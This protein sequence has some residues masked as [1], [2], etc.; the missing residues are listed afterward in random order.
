MGELAV[1]TP[2][3][4]ERIGWVGERLYTMDHVTEGLRWYI[5]QFSAEKF[6][7]GVVDRLWFGTNSKK[8]IGELREAGLLDVISER[9]VHLKPLETEAQRNVIGR[10][11][12]SAVLSIYQHPPSAYAKRIRL[13]L[14][15]II[16]DLKSGSRRFVETEE[17][18]ETTE[19]KRGTP[20]WH[21]DSHAAEVAD[22]EARENHTGQYGR[23]PF[24]RGD[25][26]WAMLTVAQIEKISDFKHGEPLRIAYQTQAPDGKIAE[27]YGEYYSQGNDKGSRIIAISVKDGKKEHQIR[28]FHFDSNREG[29][30][31]LGLERVDFPIIIK[32][33]PGSNFEIKAQ[34][35]DTEPKPEG[36]FQIKV[37]GKRTK[38]GSDAA[39]NGGIDLSQ[40]G[41]A[42]HI[43]KDANGGVKVDVDP[44]LIARVE[45]EGMSEIDPVIIGMRPADI[46]SL[47]GVKVLTS[48][49]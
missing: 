39:M 44:A 4:N 11:G 37:V 6:P 23:T 28:M 45:R 34:K 33:R 35:R 42:L 30:Q 27:I 15:Y 18:S 10:I 16:N 43:T 24:E 49:P 36:D 8:I 9:T 17:T 14:Q 26:D 29:D 1:H 2:I 21:P 38:S 48:V 25:W 41:S 20:G 3:Y 22:R 47:F 46:Q 12:G 5:E 19:F 13:G 7:E 31:I 40:Q 32:K